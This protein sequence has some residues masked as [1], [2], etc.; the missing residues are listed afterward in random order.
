MAEPS[1][2]DTVMITRAETG[3]QVFAAARPMKAN[4]YE[5]AKVMEH[6]L[7]DGSSVSDHIVFMAVEIEQPLIIAGDQLQSVFDEIRQLF[8][9]GEVLDV[10]TRARTYESMVIQA[11]PHDEHGDAPDS[12]VVALQLKEAK[13]ISTQYAGAIGPAQVGTTATT[14]PRASTVRRGAQQTTTPA[15]AVE[16]QGS[17]LYRT[18][19]GG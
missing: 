2:A 11:I 1:S 5:V 12:V 3:E 19:G 9:A 8:L 17:I 14:A 6:P 10:R 7:E 15:P 13:F 4:V 16:E 18:F